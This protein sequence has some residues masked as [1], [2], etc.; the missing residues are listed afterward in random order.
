M[1]VLKVRMRRHFL[2]PEKVDAVSAEDLAAEASN[3]DSRAALSK[4]ITLIDAK[5]DCCGPA[6]G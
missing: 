2:P 3:V 1:L 4:S 5:I 6:A